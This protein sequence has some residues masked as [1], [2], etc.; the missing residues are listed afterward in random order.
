MRL[1][2][3]YRVVLVEGGNFDEKRDISCFLAPVVF[4]DLEDASSVC[5][6]IGAEK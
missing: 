4:V 1:T 2:L 6:G 3:P 5:D